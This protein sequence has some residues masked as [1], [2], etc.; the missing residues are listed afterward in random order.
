MIFNPSFA[1]NQPHMTPQTQWNFFLPIQW[2]LLDPYGRVRVVGSCLLCPWGCHWPQKFCW[3]LGP[4]LWF[5]TQVLL[6]INPNDT[7]EPVKLFLAHT[8]VFVGS[9]WK[10]KSDWFLFVIPWGCQWP[11]KFCWLMLGFITMILNPSFAE[12]QPHMTPQTQWK[13]S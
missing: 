3:L 1:K 9:I 13:S 12:N 5:L 10:S 8:M 2:C 4:S 6:I 11:Q 7:T